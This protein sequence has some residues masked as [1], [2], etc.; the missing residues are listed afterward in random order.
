MPQKSK[1]NDN[2]DTA[3]NSIDGN[4]LSEVSSGVEDLELDMVR[5]SIIFPERNIFVYLFP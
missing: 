3:N 2:F 1:G 5:F 4:D